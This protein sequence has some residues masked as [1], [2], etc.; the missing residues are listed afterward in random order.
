MITSEVFWE[1]PHMGEDLPRWP[2]E[3][4]LDLLPSGRGCT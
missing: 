1:D 4:C 2:A 3:H